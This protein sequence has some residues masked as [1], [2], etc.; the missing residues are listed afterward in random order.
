MSKAC[1]LNNYFNRDNSVNAITNAPGAASPLTI[2]TWY[3]ASAFGNVHQ[4]VSF[5]TNDFDFLC[6]IEVDTGGQVRGYVVKGSTAQTI[7]TASTALSTATWYHLAVTWD[8]TTVR[9]YVNGAEAA[10][11][12]GTIT[13]Q[14]AI[15]YMECG[16]VA[17]GSD[18]T[19]IQDVTYWSAALTASQVQELYAQRQPKRR[20]NLV[21][22]Y[23]MWTGGTNTVDYSGNANNGIQN[24][25]VADGTITAPAKW[26]GGRPQRIYIASGATNIT[27]AGTTQTTGTATMTASAGLAAAGTTQTTG[28]ASMTASAGLAAA[29]TTRTTGSAAMTI[30]YAITATGLTRTNGSAAVSSSSGG[31]GFLERDNPPRRMIPVAGRRRVR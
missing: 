18:V 29:G 28:T 2:S 10:N 20:S 6:V 7:N 5:G 14:P 19:T 9:L 3:H 31:G 4:A 25:T 8:G 13:S 22:H 1:N 17:S 12:T 27:A 26:A 24:G 23:P 15:T 11:N 21:A 30:T 16:Y